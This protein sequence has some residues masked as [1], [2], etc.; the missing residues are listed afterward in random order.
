MK[1]QI[2][3]IKAKLST[4]WIVVLINMVFADIFSIMVELVNKDTLHIPG[5]VKV[6]MA[7]AAVVTNIPIMMIYLS[8]VLKYK[9]NRIANIV[10]AI[11]TIIYV[12]GGGD[13]VP[14]YLII[15]TIEVL[16]LITIIFY[17]LKW[18]N[19]ENE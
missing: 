7:I 6:I 1:D 11:L 19:I 18:K 15:A 17:S 14:H 8:R 16:L 10:A 12:I 5:D 2:M 13:T 3:D 4:L 9:S